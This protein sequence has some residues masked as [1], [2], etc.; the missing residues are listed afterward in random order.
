MKWFFS[1]SCSWNRSH[2]KGKKM[3]AWAVTVSKNQETDCPVLTTPL[4][5]W[6]VNPGV[7]SAKQWAQK[8]EEKTDPLINVQL[9]VQIPL[10]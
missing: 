1:I 3:L 2:F 9:K 8:M 5:N 10:L 4:S 7:I 6:E